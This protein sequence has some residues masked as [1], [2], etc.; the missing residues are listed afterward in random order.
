LPRASFEA[1]A[2]FR[3]LLPPATPSLFERLIRVAREM[4][5]LA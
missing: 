5:G 1:V 2:N 3:P 4:L